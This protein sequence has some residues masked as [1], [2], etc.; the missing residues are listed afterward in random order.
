MSFWVE[1]HRSHLRFFLHAEMYI[2]K[3]DVSMGANDE[4]TA[5]WAPAINVDLNAVV[6][7]YEVVL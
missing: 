1:L 4:V 6:V 3:L 7:R 5:S 2:E